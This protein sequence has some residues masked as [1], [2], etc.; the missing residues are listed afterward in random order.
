MN[1]LLANLLPLLVTLVTPP[2]LMLV[3]KLINSL[4]AKW[5]LGNIDKY[6]EQ[7]D[8]L[9]KQGIMAA[10][11][12]AANQLKTLPAGQAVPSSLKLD[13]AK[14]AIS[15]SITYH[16]LAMPTD[17]HMTAMVESAIFSGAKKVGI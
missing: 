4:V 1:I 11:Q 15:S 17:A 3:H 14:Q 12:W 10:E 6:S 13:I 7:L 16:K 8:D 2:L 9:V 5:N